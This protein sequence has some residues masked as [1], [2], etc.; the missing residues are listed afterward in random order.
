MIRF[1][2]DEALPGQNVLLRMHWAKRNRLRNRVAWLVKAALLAPESGYRFGSPP[3]QR[4]R[5]TITRRCRKPLDPDNLP[6]SAKH[7]LDILQ[8]HSKTHP[9]GLGVIQDDSKACILELSVLQEPGKGQ[10]VVE[11]EELP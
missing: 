3:I 7:A 8:P 5:V 2:I 10:T 9:L 1:T 11:I 6:S 4:C